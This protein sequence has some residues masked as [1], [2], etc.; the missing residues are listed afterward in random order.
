MPIATSATA[1]DSKVA[2]ADRASRDAAFTLAL[3]LP[4]DTLLYLLLP[5]YAASFGVT[6]PEAGFLLAANRLV[7]IAGYGIVARFYSASGA[8]AACLLAAF[9]SILAA[10]IYA[11]QSGVWALLVGRLVWGLSFAAMNIANQALPTSVAAGAAK[12]SGLSRAIIALGPAVSLV[13]GAL[14]TLAYG[15]RSVFFA[16]TALA[17]LA[18]VFAARLPARPETSLTSAARFGWPEPMS[19]WSFALGFTLDGLFVF[20]LGLL[21]AASFP[22]GAVM[23]AALA[24][25]LRY[26]TEVIFSPAGG[27]LAHRYGAYHII[28]AASL[29]ATLGLAALATE[30]AMLWTAVVVTIVLR[31]LI[32]P[33]TAPM[34]AEAYPGAGRVQALARQATWR[35][36]GAATGPLAAGFVLPVLPPLA[37]YGTAALVLGLST[38][39][40][41]SARGHAVQTREHDAH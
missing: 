21:A 19:I 31:A 25:A 1:D 12:R 27:R 23:A 11:T 20:G 28:V 7:R 14:M 2:E 13:A 3:T 9:G 5:I 22:S 40:L 16:L 18:P 10:L 6:L 39:A 32:Q 26:A 34:V 35:D 37:V 33:L 36:I 4:G 15:P 41:T 8:R 24:L 17:C 29:G 38:L 30:G